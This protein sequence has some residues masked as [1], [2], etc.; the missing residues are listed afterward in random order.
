M[1]GEM[2]CAACH[3]LKDMKDI[4]P[5]ER[6]APNLADVGSR[7]APEFLRKFVAS[8][9]AA[10]GGTAMPDLLAAESA[11]ERAK[12]AESITHFLVAQSPR[13]FQ[14]DKIK[15][16][17]AVAGKAI[18][19]TIGCVACHSS[20][21]D[22]G[23]ETTQ[24][25]IVELAH[26][27][28]KYSLVSLAEF[29]QDPLRVR[30]SGRMPDLK[31]T[32][33]E[34]KAL[35][36]YLLGK[37]DAPV[38][39][40]QPQPG[41]V[42][43]GKKHFQRLNCASCHKF[44]GIAAA[45]PVSTLNGSNLDGGCLSKM[46]GRSPRFNLSDDQAKAIRAALT[47]KATP[48][49]EKTRLATTLTA[50]NC[51]AC[52]ARDDYGGVSAERN[53]HFKTSEINLGEEARIPPPLTLV[54]A[55]LRPVAVKKMLF[56]GDSV[57]PYM[58]TRMPQFGESNL[59][60]LPKLFADLDSVA[61]V[62]LSIPNVESPNKKE[63]ER[64]REL[65]VA[66]REMLGNKALNCIACHTFNG[67]ASN[68]KGIDLMISYQRLQPS[69]FYHYLRDPNAFRPRTIMPTSWPDGQ[70]MLK[71]VLDGKTDRQIEAIWY[72]LSLGTSAA[73]PPGIQNVAT[74]IAVTDA[75]HTYRGRSNVAGYRGIAV[76]FP[77]KLN[78]AF[79]A[80]TGTLSAIWRGDFINVDR[81]GQ[82][83]G[84]FRPAS[85]FVELAQDLSFFD[86]VNEK[87]SW[88]LRP[89]MTK[90]APVNPDP[91]YPKNRGYQ[92]KGYQLDD[93]SIPTFLYR[94][95]TIEIEDRSVPADAGKDNRLRRHLM[96]HS[97]KEQTLWFRALTGKIEA[98]SKERFKT[99]QIRLSI[100]SVPA[101]LRAN[102][103]DKNTL[104]LLLRFDIPK[105]QSTRTVTYELLR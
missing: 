70:A 74:K 57:R 88:P 33:V 95:T 87:T 64:E 41:L 26:V 8:P 75:T 61:K 46:P 47:Q 11:E 36:S 48:A 94:C 45:A 78:Y 15:E 30:P 50:F 40:I 101:V 22:G 73:D 89:V 56:D 25:G 91:L 9:A 69:W 17:D 97:P 14:R 54:G 3:G 32:Q 59:S 72:Y 43:L 99:D 66:G 13:K 16:E 5:L 37:A 27:P 62:D 24:V 53:A 103:A 79:N 86:L 93:A 38:S 81:G 98:E 6:T 63:R 42:A 77:E 80:E 96:F 83:S 31:L 58:L 76:G 82:G 68:F 49:S 35:A 23:K 52:H 7:V 60:H 18:F 20:R 84:A 102:S 85:K 55:K 19:H 100:P 12:I 71:T 44:G 92:F 67:K 105:G 1:L 65:R 104:E 90:E 51:I 10:H 21:D 2:R 28:A 39:A 34:A 4:Q 29:L